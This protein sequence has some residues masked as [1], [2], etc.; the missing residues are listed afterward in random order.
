MVAPP[1]SMAPVMSTL[2]TAQQDIMALSGSDLKEALKCFD[3]ARNVGGMG[4]FTAHPDELGANMRV[5]EDVTTMVDY[6]TAYGMGHISMEQKFHLFISSAF[7]KELQKLWQA[8]Y[9]EAPAS[10]T[11]I[12]QG[13]KIYFAFLNLFAAFS[14]TSDKRKVL[15]MT[16]NFSYNVRGFKA[17]W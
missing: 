16:D 14:T 1:G 6:C 12:G 10:T 11:S 3:K 15:Q 8:A 7:S 13:S 4:M 17:T 2:A 5:L 9:R